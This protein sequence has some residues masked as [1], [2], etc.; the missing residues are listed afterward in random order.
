M[1]SYILLAILCS[2]L[3]TFS[4]RALPFAVFSGKRSMPAWLGQLGV[5]LPSS[6]MAVLIV[7]CLKGVP[8]DPIGI[9]VPSALAVLIVAVSYKWKPSTFLSIILGTAVYMRL[10]P[11]L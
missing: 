2:G 11:R 4:L 1:N 8:S 9:G 5:I 7:Y 10:N 6:I 3:V